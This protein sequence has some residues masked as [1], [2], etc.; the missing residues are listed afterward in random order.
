MTTLQLYHYGFPWPI[1]AHPRARD[2]PEPTHTFTGGGA[3]PTLGSQAVNGLHSLQLDDNRSY[4]L[5]IHRA[6]TLLNAAVQGK[7]GTRPYITLG[8]DDAIPGAAAIARPADPPGTIPDP[9]DG[10]ELRTLRIEGVWMASGD[11]PPGNARPDFVIDRAE[12]A[13]DMPD[14]SDVTIRDATFDPGGTRADGAPITA[15]R[16]VVRGRVRRLRIERCILG[17]IEVEQDEANCA[18]SGAVEELIIH[19]SIVDGQRLASR[20]AIACVTGRVELQR[21]TV[22]GNVRATLLDASDSIITGELDVSNQ[23]QSCLR[24][25]AV[26]PGGNLP[27]SF[28]TFGPARASEGTLETAIV[29]AFFVSLRFGDPGYAS[30]SLLAPVEI[31]QGAESGSEMGAFS[32]SLR[33]IRLKSTLDKVDEFK[34]A[35]VIAQYMLQGEEAPLEPNEG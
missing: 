16:I 31:R 23:Q 32:S 3:L 10:S 1:G 4:S 20:Q 19:D 30:L 13:A 15:L 35:G 5:T 8:T 29:P 12:H 27:R 24:F 14:W 21:V 2:L 11:Q 25:S 18:N 34:P 17:P 33:P 28:E 6:H 7:G 22:L 9:P 26:S